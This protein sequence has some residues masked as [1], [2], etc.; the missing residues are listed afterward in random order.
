MGN[1]PGANACCPSPRKIVVTEQKLHE[2]VQERLPK[3]T[4]YDELK[5]A[6]M[7]LREARQDQARVEE[8]LSF[9]KTNVAVAE[10]A[11]AE[12]AKKVQEAAAEALR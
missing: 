10:R 12:A 8:S 3:P 5:T 7:L 4:C 6:E 9:A 11:V 1:Y 2:M